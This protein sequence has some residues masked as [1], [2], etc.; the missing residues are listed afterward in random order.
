[1]LWAIASVTSTLPT[2]GPMREPSPRSPAA[3]SPA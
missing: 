1:M 3:I 2:I